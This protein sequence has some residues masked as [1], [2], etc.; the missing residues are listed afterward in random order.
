MNVDFNK[1]KF[2]PH[3]G[4]NVDGGNVTKVEND[5]GALFGDNEVGNGNN[6]VW[7]VQLGSISPLM[8]IIGKAILIK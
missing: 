7:S 6:G 8:L 1:D 2:L 3:H 4:D 5:N